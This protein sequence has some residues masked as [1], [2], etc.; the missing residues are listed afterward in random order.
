[1]VSK[2]N[3]RFSNWARNIQQ[4]VEQIFY[5]TSVEEVVSIVQRC[6][7]ERKKIRVVGS[8]HSFTPLAC[9]REVMVSLDE[10]Q[11]IEEINHEEGSATVWAG[12]KL[13]K[14]GE[15]LHKHGVAQEN[16]GDINAQS[17]AGA[18]TT[19]THGTGA[20]LGNLSTQVLEVT[21]V[22]A[23]GNVITSSQ[24][25]N[26]HLFKALQLSL[27]MLGIIVKVKIKVIP[28]YKLQYESKRIP[29]STC[30]EKLAHYKSSFRHFEFYCFPYSD[31]TQIKC[32]Q[33]TNAPT[34][35]QSVIHTFNETFIENGLFYVLSMACRMLPSLCKP[36]SRLSAS[37]IPST[38]KV[39]QN[40]RIFASK[41]LVKF[42]EM[43]YCI[44]AE[45]ME[46][47]ITL[48]KRTIEAKKI[49]VHFPIECRY[50][51]ADDIWLSPSYKR[52]S[53]YIAV[54]MFRGMPYASYFKEIENIFL[55]Y[56]GRPHWGKMHTLKG[57]SLQQK[58]SMLSSFLKMREEMD[59]D[60]MFLNTY[61]EDI[62]HMSPS[63]KEEKPV[64]MITTNQR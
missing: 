37:V 31:T 32:L 27:G 39:H 5:P 62:F 38:K 12:T 17:I 13:K 34:T 42:H 14:L 52:D 19:G 8:G 58:Y 15:L 44:P 20:T 22:T 10:M 33:P 26:A 57:K 18:I 3:K 9:S 28:S 56:D 59:H 21:V 7:K 6:K 41:R 48:I 61:L 16:L 63:K 2:K 46:V 53:A 1:M 47:V 29:F 60:G 50:V 43:E 25:E 4:H 24:N 36:I 35:K 11:G 40:F 49:A 23:D 51:K 30:M 45:H 55:E 54:H 64:E